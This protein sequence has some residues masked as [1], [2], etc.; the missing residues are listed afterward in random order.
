[1]DDAMSI[2]RDLVDQPGSIRETLGN[3]VQQI[4]NL[5]KKSPQNY[6]KLDLFYPRILCS[7][8]D[9]QD[10]K[11]KNNLKTSLFASYKN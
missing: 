9:L 8:I 7:L 5:N 11:P 1:M 3:G 6:R 10:T 2:F 4:V